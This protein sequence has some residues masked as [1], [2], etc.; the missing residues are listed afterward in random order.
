MQ[1]FTAV[2]NPRV[3]NR[4]I[5]IGSTVSEELGLQEGEIVSLFIGKLSIV[6][7]ILVRP[8]LSRYHIEFNPSVF[9]K[10]LLNNHSKYGIFKKDDGLHIG[11]LIGIMAD[12]YGDTQRPFDGQTHFISQLHVLGGELGEI[13]YAFSPY[14]VNFHSKTIAGYYYSN[15]YWRRGTFP[16]PDVVYPR[17]GGYSPTK[18]QIRQKLQTAGCRFIN[19]P[20]IGKWE[21]HKILMQNP[22]INAYIPDT[23]L[24]KGF[25]QVERMLNKYGAVYL[26][27]I[28]GSMGRN[29]I[30]VVKVRHSNTYSYQYQ[31]HSRTH[32]GSATG[33]KSLYNSLRKVMGKRQYIVQQRLNLFKF[34]GNIADVRILVQKDDQGQW[35]ITG[36]AVRI[37]KRGSITSNISSGG[38]AKKVRAVLDQKFSDPL[39]KDAIMAEID[40]IALEAAGYLEQHINSIGELGIDIG[41]DT[42]GKLWFIEANLRP[43]RQVFTLI[44]E[45]N[46]RKSSVQKP[47]LYAR[48]LAGLNQEG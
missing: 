22:N 8:D 44:G 10:L 26:K 11:P 9:K 40:Y 4:N 28:A 21:T 37:G 42:T 18:L 34:I 29:I 30:K 15:G 33:I 36:K 1:K 2:K 7:E 16:F 41:I 31:I 23:R 32:S 19:P 35:H 47:L 12:V 17:E 25:G 24:I 13:C 39:K 45:N 14:G 27:P 46:T 5:A 48:Y 43:A 38:S 20:L 3:S 6:Q